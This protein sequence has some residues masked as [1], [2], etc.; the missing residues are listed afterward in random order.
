MFLLSDQDWNID[1]LLLKLMKLGS[2]QPRPVVEWIEIHRLNFSKYVSITHKDLLSSYI[3]A[4]K[5]GKSRSF[6]TVHLR[7][8]NCHSR[9]ATI[10][11]IILTI[12][13]TE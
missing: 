7:Q 10:E 6:F 2:I 12:K 11:P 13:G 3:T 5:P 8:C 1:D 9:L 4:F